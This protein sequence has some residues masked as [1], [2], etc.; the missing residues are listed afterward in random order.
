MGVRGE[1][2]QFPPPW[3]LAHGDSADSLFHAK[4]RS[5]EAAKGNAK[6]WCSVFGV[7]WASRGRESAG[8]R[9]FRSS[10]FP[11]RDLSFCDW[12]DWR[13]WHR[14]WFCRLF[15]SR[16]AAKPRRETQGA[17]V[18]CVCVCVCVCVNCLLSSQL[19]RIYS[20][21]HGCHGPLTPD[22]SPPFHGGEGRI[23]CFLR[24]SWNFPISRCVCDL[25]VVIRGLQL[26]G[27]DWL[28]LTSASVD[29]RW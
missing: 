4:P 12:T 5:R 8:V 10:G 14:G 3:L 22:P 6:G 28:P 19:S 9:R 26:A 13:L 16:E 23:L 27:T 21:W 11:A 25:S 17:A 18:V 24:P 7:R 29:W 2:A 20:L 1:T 15:V